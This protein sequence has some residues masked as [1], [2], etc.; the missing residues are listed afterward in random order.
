MLSDTPG[1]RLVHLESKA[2]EELGARPSED[3]KK[4]K[5][6]SGLY[7]HGLRIELEGAYPAS[8]QYLERLEGSRWSLLWD[9]FDYEVQQYPNGRATIDLHTIS[10]REEWIGV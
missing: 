8:V 2:P 3:A 4:K 10:D 1:L 5:V 7:R 9:R 6:G